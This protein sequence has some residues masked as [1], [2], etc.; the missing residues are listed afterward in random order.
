MKKMKKIMWIAAFVPVIVTSIV[1]QFL[2]DVIPMHYDTK[3]NIDRWGSKSESFVLPIIILV[4]TLFW[5]LLIYFFEKKAKNADTEKA[6]MEARSNVKVLYIVGIVQALMF[7]IM[8]YFSLYSAYIQ[9]STESNKTSGDMAKVSC[10]LC[11]LMIVVLGNYMTKTKINSAVGL[12]TV[13]SMHNDNTW[14]KSNRFAAITFIIAGLLTI[15]TTVF[16][17]GMLSTVGLL[18]YII[19]AAIASVIYSKIVYDQE[20]K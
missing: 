20:V 3:G 16:A 13:W 8:Q 5:H 14:R 10:I 11:G 6:Q 18:V 9:V 17:S 1:L 19:I 7:G 15:I 12:R 4:V 2:P